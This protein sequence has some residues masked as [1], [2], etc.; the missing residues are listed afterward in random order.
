MKSSSEASKKAWDN[1]YK[2]GK[3]KE[4]QALAFTETIVEFIQKKLPKKS[5]GLYVGCGNGRNFVPLVRRGLD[6]DGVD[7]SGVGINEIRNRL[8]G[9]SGSLNVGDFRDIQG[10]T[11]DYLISLQVF[12]HGS[13]N[14]L[15]SFYASSARLL[16]NSGYLFLRV[17]ASTTQLDLGH[18]ILEG[19]KNKSRTVKY[20][21]GHKAVGE[22]L[23]HF[24]D[25]DELLQLAN[26]NGFK[27]T[28]PPLEDRTYR[29]TPRGGFWSQWETIWQK[30]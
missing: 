13:S 27:V 10:Q 19:E 3:Y 7:I 17:N 30:A 5:K 1:A 29:E 28:P 18:V 12:Q 2:T 22:V 21:E 14:E 25:K 15:N 26:D 16:K 6:L 20:T 4:A 8:P 11:W 9:Y 24:Y 23:I